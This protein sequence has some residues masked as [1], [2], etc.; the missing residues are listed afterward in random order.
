[1]EQPPP[2]VDD[3]VVVPLRTIILYWDPEEGTV[4]ADVGKGINALE[5][6]TWVS[7]AKE[8]IWASLPDSTLVWRWGED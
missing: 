1:M 8:A 3:E 4:K 5:A 6:F 7:L 2:E